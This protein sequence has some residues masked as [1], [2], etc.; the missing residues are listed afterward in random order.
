M[1]SAKKKLFHISD[2]YIHIWLIFI[3]Y[4][5]LFHLVFL[6]N[7]RLKRVNLLEY[8]RLKERYV[9]NTISIKWVRSLEP[10][11]VLTTVKIIIKGCASW[12]F[13][14]FNFQLAETYGNISRIAV[15]CSLKSI[16]TKKNPLKPITFTGFIERLQVQNLKVFQLPRTA[17]D[18]SRHS[19]HKK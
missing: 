12:S 4:R 11:K 19:M 13:L 7:A 10:K 16:Q 17:S 14:L 9:Y 8:G 2:T 18:R 15:T 6:I 3:L 5:S 1:F